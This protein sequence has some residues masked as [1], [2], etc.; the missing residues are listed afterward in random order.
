MSPNPPPFHSGYTPSYGS[1]QGPPPVG[2]PGAGGFQSPYPPPN[3]NNPFQ[4]PNPSLPPPSG[5]PPGQYPSPGGPPPHQPPSGPPNQNQ[6]NPPTG[7]PNPNQWTPPSGPPPP[8]RQDGYPGQQ[9][10]QGPNSFN[11]NNGGYPG[12]NV[13]R[14]PPGP[15]GPPSQGPPSIPGNRPANPPTYGEPHMPSF[16][17]QVVGPQGHQFAYQ[18]SK[19][20]GKKKALCVSILQYPSYVSLRLVHQPN[21]L[22]T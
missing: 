13:Y 20:N 12:S 9:G 7:P 11:Q 17:R 3:S 4:V 1:P 16:D 8:P 6:W 22:V 5:P 19:C 2:F 15:P 21:L 14:P 10:Q 18:Y